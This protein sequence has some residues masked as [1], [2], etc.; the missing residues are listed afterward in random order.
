M[1]LDSIKSQDIAEGFRMF[2]RGRFDQALTTFRSMLQKLLLVA[3]K[4]DEEA[5][6]VSDLMFT[7]LRSIDRIRLY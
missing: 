7:M 5:A 2:S 3:V 4:N 1:S 6:E